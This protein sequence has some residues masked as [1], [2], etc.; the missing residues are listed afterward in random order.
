[1][2]LIL[3]HEN[4][5]GSITATFYTIVKAHYGEPHEVWTHGNPITLSFGSPHL[6]GGWIG[7]HTRRLYEDRHHKKILQLKKQISR[8]D[9]SGIIVELENFDKQKF[10]SQ[11]WKTEKAKALSNSKGFWQKIKT[12]L[13]FRI[14]KEREYEY[15]REK[16]NELKNKLIWQC[17]NEMEKF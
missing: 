2:H 12:L 3:L 14:S 1:M 6:V 17:Q 11:L 4:N 5:N 15:V 7:E 13:V 8:G 9:F 16:T 10:L